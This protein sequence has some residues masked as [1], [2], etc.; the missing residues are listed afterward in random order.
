MISFRFSYDVFALFISIMTVF[1]V[2]RIRSLGTFRNRVFFVYVLTVLVIC[3]SDLTQ[4]IIINWLPAFTLLKRILSCLN[5]TLVCFVPLT[6]LIYIF[7][8]VD[9]FQM[10]RDDSKSMLPFRIFF[11]ISVEVFLIWT[12][13]FADG[14]DPIFTYLDSFGGFS[15]GIVGYIILFVFSLYYFVFGILTM[16]QHKYRLEKNSLI[17][18]IFGFL[19]IILAIIVQGANPDIRVVPI[20]LAF[21]LILFSLFVQKPE[22]LKSTATDVLNDKAFDIIVSDY[23][24]HK[25]NFKVV[26]LYAEDMVFYRAMLGQNE[27]AGLDQCIIRRLRSLFRDTPLLK[28]DAHGFYYLLFK[29][30]NSADVEST[31]SKINEQIKDRWGYKGLKFDFKFRV[32]VVDGLLDIKSVSE[33]RNFACVFTRQNQYKGMCLN[34]MDIDSG[35]I[36]KCSCAETALIGGNFNEIIEVLYQPIYSVQAKRITRAE[37]V[38]CFKN[39]RSMIVTTDTFLPVFERTGQFFN[40][41]AFSFDAVC[42]LLSAVNPEELGLEKIGINISIIDTTQ[43]DLFEQIKNRLEYFGVSPYL[44]H[45]EINQST[46]IKNPDIIDNNLHKLSTYGIDI[47][48][49]NFGFE[50]SNIEQLVSLSFGIIK[51]DARAVEMAWGNSKVGIALKSLVRMAH[52]LGIQVIANGVDTMEQRIWLEGIE[53]DYLQGALFCKPVPEDE[54]IKY[55]KNTIQE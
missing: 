8:L 53:C 19:L 44:V 29:N 38:L 46:Y 39:D 10:V 20:T 41:N 31:L 17:L 45:F 14:N 27:L 25:Y 43:Q 3:T 4:T 42:N 12:S 13:L 21:S 49:D 18:M 48:L 37:S 15:H 23:L 54:F 35:M 52:D 33:L 7:S 22:Y 16:I 5:Y 50:N 11:P 47:V 2:V 55:M 1:Y 28:D 36:Q 6:F 24:E 34:A 32:C 51:L 9:Y 40:V 30:A 26:L